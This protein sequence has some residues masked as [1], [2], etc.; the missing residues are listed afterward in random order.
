MAG[1]RDRVEREAAPVEEVKEVA[2]P[3]VEE[4]VVEAPV[5]E[6]PIVEAPP[7]APVQLRYEYQPTDEQGRNLGGKQVILYTTPDELASKL[8]EQN[9]QLVRKL[10]EVTRKQKL[11]I[12]DTP[13]PP[14]GQ[15]FDTAVDLEEKPLSTE[16]VFDLTQKL[17]DPATFVEARDALLESALGVSPAEFRKRYNEQQQLTLQLLVKSNYDIF[18]RQ[19]TDF[20]PSAENKQL[21]TDWMSKKGLAP[22]V[23]NFEFA[24]STLKESGLILEAPT[25]R[26]VSPAPPAPPAAPAL[27][28]E[29]PPAAPAPASTEPKPVVPASNESRITPPATPAATRQPI[30]VPSGLT[31]NVTSVSGQPAK[32]NSLTVAEFEKMPADEVKKRLKDPVFAK[33]VNDLYTRKPVQSQI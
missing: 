16:Q 32:A 23:A 2:Q 9:T 1:L 22:T 3:V 18:E 24:L 17:N 13:K 15:I 4:P 12:D 21:L 25:V 7:V 28:A 31:N 26:E 27:E 30:R 10:R 11:G 20:V 8:S 19:H 29:V 14:D 5:V 33:Q 6:E